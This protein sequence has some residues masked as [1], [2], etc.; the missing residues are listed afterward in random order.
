MDI[1]FRLIYA[2]TAPCNG[3]VLKNRIMLFKSLV[4]VF[5]SSS[6][7]RI[8]FVLICKTGKWRLLILDLNMMKKVLMIVSEAPPVQSGVARVADKL[9]SGLRRRGFQV[10]ILSL[11]DI[12]RIEFGEIRLSSMPLKLNSLKERLSDYDL[13]H[14][15]GPVPTF[16][17]SFLLGGLRGM[18]SKRPN[19]VYTHHSPIELT[20]PAI[21]PFLSIYNYLQE[22]WS[23]LADHVVASTPSYGQRLSRYVPAEKL[24][25]V[26]WGVDFNKFYAPVEKNH[27]FTVLYLGQ[28]RPYKG[29]PVFLKAADHLAATRFWVIGD[30]HYAETCQMA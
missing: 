3:L 5:S 20:S 6:H 18:G 16:S 7:I 30:G 13:V 25:V 21:R 17:D 29:L 22:R 28:I 9:S 8:N 15:H 19:L 11:P 14:L 27:P 12:P 24:S 26:P 23:N 4:K 10:D 2:G 1:R